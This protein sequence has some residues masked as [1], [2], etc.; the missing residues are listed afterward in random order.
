MRKR[1]NTRDF[2]GLQFF[3]APPAGDRLSQIEAR[4]SQIRTEMDQE[5]ADL[6]ALSNEVDNLI[7]ERGQL[8]QGAETRA[9]L[10]RKI[11]TGTVGNP[12][13]DMQLPGDPEQRSETYTIDSPEYR[14]AWIKS[15]RNNAYVG[16]V[17]PLT[18]AE[19]R[20]FTTVAGSAGAA[21]PTQTA[22]TILE[23][24]TQYAPL[25][26]KI[27]LLRVP[28]MVTFAVED[29]VNA[30]AYH[31]ENDTISASTDKLKSI[32]LSAY[33][34]TKLIPISKSVK[35]MSIPAFETWL[36]DSL[37]RSIADKISETI[38][39]GTGSTQ[40]TGIDKAATW[41]QSTNSVQIGSAAS[42]TTADVLK[43]ISLLPGGY[44]ARAEFIMSKQTLFND[45]MPLQDKSKNDI[46]VM[47]GGSYYIYGYP[48]Q[49]D[50]RVKAH[51]AYLG[52]LYT[53]IGNMP[54]DVTVTSAFDIDT[55]S[56]KF[57][58]CAMFDCKP[59]MSDA[60]VK[61]EKAAG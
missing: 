58:G 23:K 57:L 48:V 10:L 52:D 54:E 33:E 35:L 14:T 42:L 22:N 46:V 7:A 30:A 4:L 39:L 60:F 37:A 25:L 27:N 8:K 12:L 50:Q 41:D 16:T 15:L 28:G 47:S 36:V 1:T 43:L 17:D 45:F 13:P 61:L 18:D 9:A 56:Y 44:D 6:E 31:T 53:V 40:G 11:G 26:S 5:G 38:L 3:A 51:E 21:I 29:T 49:L 34:I 24:V 32:T 20:A 19:Q 55:N 59:S 2:I